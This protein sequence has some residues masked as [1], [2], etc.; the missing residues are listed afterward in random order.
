[1]TSEVPEVTKARDWIRTVRLWG[2]V[3]EIEVIGESPDEE[4]IHRSL[5]HRDIEDLGDKLSV[6]FGIV[7]RKTPMS[8]G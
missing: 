5:A 4:A 8:G 2:R 1:M 7:K 6:H 3:V